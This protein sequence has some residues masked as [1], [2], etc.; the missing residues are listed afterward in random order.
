MFILLTFRGK[1]IAFTANT[2]FKAKRLIGK[3]F[4]EVMVQEDINL[5][6]FRVI[7]G[8]D[9]IP[10]VIVT[11]KGH[12]QQFS[13]EEI[14]SMFL[15]KMKEIAEAYIGGTTTGSVEKKVLIF[16]L[17]G[18]TFDVSLLTIDGVGKFDVKAVASDTHLG[19]EDFDNRMVNYCVDDFK[20]KWNKDLK[21]N[22]R[23]LGRL[24]VA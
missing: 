10:K 20:K 9:E 16:D 19:G 21:E 15:T 11:Y 13:T 22:G 17:G 24:K 7:K 2:V 14:S 1:E 8:S 18:G 3:R 12:E 6:S 4:S 5:L 23:A